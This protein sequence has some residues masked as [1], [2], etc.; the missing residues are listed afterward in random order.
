VAPE[1]VDVGGVKLAYERAG[2]G[3]PML[4]I[5]G[6]PRD[7]R[8]WRKLVPLLGD[9]FDTVAM[10]RR[11]YGESDRPTDPATYANRTMAQDALELT[12]RLGWQRFVVVGH[13]LGQPVAQRLAADH[14]DTVASA[15][16]LDAL[17]QGVRY[18][19][20]DPSGRS[21]YFDFFRQ[22]GVAEQIIGQNPRLFFSLFLD[23]NTHLSPEEHAAFLEPFCRAGS[24][25]AVLADYRHRIEDDRLYWEH[26][27]SSGRK[28][29]TPVLVLWAAK[30]PVAGAPVLEL[31][32]TAADNVRGTEITNTAHY[33][34]EEQPE[35]VARHMLQFADEQSTRM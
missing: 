12:Q 1:Y 34:Q 8:L 25:E 22:R 20:H 28:I 23:R 26:W 10:D 30:G 14:P 32:Q 7:R 29:Q 16:F 35:E 21:W 13:D 5:H 9:R 15:V 6:F 27:L 18:E 24:V 4:L 19:R 11:G 31:W 2:Q 17:P 33:L 3:F